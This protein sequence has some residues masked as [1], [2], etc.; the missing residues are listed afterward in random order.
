[1]DYEML[2]IESLDFDTE[3]RRVSPVA[4]L[5]DNGYLDLINGP[6]DHGWCMGYTCQKRLSLFPILLAT[7]KS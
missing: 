1:M 2:H 7:G 5:S 4:I 6:Q 3:S